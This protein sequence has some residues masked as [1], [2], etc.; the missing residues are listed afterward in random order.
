MRFC[1]RGSGASRRTS[2][3]RRAAPTRP[4][5]PTP[6]RSG[7]APSAPPPRS[8]SDSKYV[9][10]NERGERELLVGLVLVGHTVQPL[11]DTRCA[12]RRSCPRATA[13]HT[14]GRAAAA[15][16]PRVHGLRQRP[17]VPG[18]PPHLR[19]GRGP[20]APPLPKPTDKKQLGWDRRHRPRPRQP[21]ACGALDLA[22][23]RLL[24]R[25]VWR[26]PPS[27]PPPPSSAA[28]ASSS[29]PWP[30]APA[31]ASPPR[32]GSRRRPHATCAGFRRRVRAGYTAPCPPPPGRRADR[33]AG[34]G[35]RV[36]REQAIKGRAPL[37]AVK[38]APVPS[39]GAG[40][41]SPRRRAH[42]RCCA[43]VVVASCEAA[44][45]AP[46]PRLHASARPHTRGG[47]DGRLAWVSRSGTLQGISRPSVLGTGN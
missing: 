31:T 20:A 27:P 44:T 43:L 3:S 24:P 40:V 7:P 32:R 23:S 4:R 36:T 45:A 8:Y 35:G 18:V 34:F 26:P 2:P 6:P 9:H 15:A 21:R 13:C 17:R 12:C 25:V 28:A 11:P 39:S 30:P 1:R 37:H 38:R 10:K 46:C 41:A 22:R 5:A 47:L 33:V 14:G 19:D 42:V 29:S 16:E